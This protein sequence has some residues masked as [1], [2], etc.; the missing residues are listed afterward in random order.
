M[1]MKHNLVTLIVMMILED[2]AAFQVLFLVFS[3]LCLEPSS[4]LWRSTGAFT[5]LKFKSAKCFYILPVVLVLVLLF[6]SWSWS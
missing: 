3:I 5:Y 6:R 1:L 2:T 4:L